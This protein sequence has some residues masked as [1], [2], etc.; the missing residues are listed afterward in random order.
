MR[1]PAAGLDAPQEVEDRRLRAPPRSP[2]TST[3]HSG[4]APTF[5]AV[6]RSSIARTRARARLL[7]PPATAGALRW[8]QRSWPKPRIRAVSR[9]SCRR[10]CDAPTNPAA[11]TLS[12]KC[13]PGE[14]RALQQRRNR[15]LHKL[16]CFAGDS[17]GLVEA[18]K[19]RGRLV[20][21]CRSP[22]FPPATRSG[23]EK[24]DFPP[25]AAFRNVEKLV[26][27]PGCFG[28]LRQAETK[29]RR[30][31]GACASSRGSRAGSRASTRSVA[32]IA[33]PKKATAP[34]STRDL[35]A[36]SA[37][38]FDQLS[39]ASVT[40]SVASSTTSSSLRRELRGW[41]T[42]AYACASRSW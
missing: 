39:V 24:V 35:G 38:L 21:A 17:I 42:G 3:F 34:R 28:G 29:R 11:R 37:R 26:L 12:G 19:F 25:W 2:G 31:S 16:G 18:P 4:S 1:L 23:L 30:S 15:G 13:R 27:R 32:E 36:V 14:P 10:R 7:P 41:R 5:S 20:R 22:K 6:Q 40:T 8:T 9:P 33:D